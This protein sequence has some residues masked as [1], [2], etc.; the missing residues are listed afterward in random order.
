MAGAGWPPT[1]HG[2]IHPPAVTSA[3]R[4]F[5]SYAR[6]DGT[7]LAATLRRRLRDEHGFSLWQDLADLEGGRDW[8][9]QITGAIDHVEY[10]VLVMTTAALRSAV[11]RQE[12]RYAR[13]QGR[14]VIPVMGAADLDFSALPGWMRRAHCVNPGV[15]EQ[16]TRFVRTLESPCRAT[17]VPLMAE[18]PPPD[19][20]PRRREIDALRSRLL[21]ARQEPVAITAALL[22]AGGY[23]KTTLA[24]AVCH[25]DAVAD[26]FHDGILWVTLG[27]QPGDLAGKVEDLIV[28]L[29]GSPSGLSSLETRTARLR[30]LLADSSVLLVVD[31]LW[32]R[33]HLEPFLAGPRCARLI[34]TR[35]SDTL[36]G[37]AREVRVDAMQS[38]EAVTLLGW[39]LPVGEDVALTRLAGR[40]GEWPLLLTLVNGV[41][42]D[43]IARAGDSLPSALAYADKVLDRRGLTGFD[44]RDA[45]Q[46]HQAVA[47]T[48]GVSLERLRDAE[49]A[50]LRELAVFPEDVEVPIATVELLWGE[51]AALDEFGTEELLHRLAQL[52]LLV[53]FDLATRRV[54]LHDVVRTYLRDEMDA[55]QLAAL[56]AAVVG[57]YRARSPG[58]WANGPDD[59]YFFRHLPGHLAAAG[60]A[61]ELRALLLDFRW[62]T[63]K[64]T[65]A[66]VSALLADYT[67]AADPAVCTLGRALRLS[68]HVLAR[69]PGA[70]ASQLLGRIDTAAEPELGA[71]LA[72]QTEQAG[73]A[74][75]LRPRSASLRPPGGALLQTLVGHTDRVTSVAVTPAGTQLV[76]GSDDHT[77]K[78]WD[79][80][81][82]LELATLAGH[83]DMVLSVA[84]TPDGTRALSASADDTVKIWDLAAAREVATLTG[85]R[86]SVRSVAVS[87]DGRHAVSASD[88]CTAK[89]WDLAS[90]RAVATLT[91]HRRWVLAVVVTP[92]GTRVLSGSG[93]SSL[94]V[95]DL[96]SGRDLATFE[97]H[98]DGVCSL[99]VTPDG[100]R[101]LSG[102]LDK[103]VKVWDL[104]SG[105]ELM[106]LKGHRSR[107]WT[108]AVTPDGTRAVFSSYKAITVC[109]LADG[110]E[111]AS[112]AGHQERV[113]A[114]VVTP[115]GTRAVSGADDRTLMVWDLASQG[116]RAVPSHEGEICT[117]AVTPDGARVVSGSW[118]RTVRVWDVASARPLA[119]LLDSRDVVTSVAVTADGTRAVSGCWDKTLTVW[120]LVGGRHLATLAGHQAEVSSVAVAPDGRR[121]VSGSWDKTV[122]VWDLASGRE[123]AILARHEAE[124]SALAVTPDGTCVVAGCENATLTVTA[125]DGGRALATLSGHAAGIADTV[126]TPDGTRVLSASWD[127]TVKVWDLASGREV[128]T[129]RGHD[130]RVTAIAVTP[131]GTRAISGS[132]DLTL[133]LWDLATGRVLATFYADAAVRAVACAGPHLVVAG[134]ADAVVHFLDLRG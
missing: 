97:G 117:L 111:I 90:G 118:D 130:G 103:T 39:G 6:S 31:D 35:N 67:R 11:V 63:A 131:D 25:D 36:P 125:L 87:R 119:T 85:H 100:T 115:D 81:S 99:A 44:P 22:G 77:V 121:A 23:G 106:A 57:C 49:R 98:D 59:G 84:I 68:A 50:R 107:I 14:C 28:A 18:P 79:L 34:T 108:V 45:E 20:V 60:K 102:S 48:L 26:A 13:Q 47:T 89:V 127:K 2:R 116:R 16:W 51:T 133:R 27:E 19:Y 126:V 7:E 124:V 52:S 71:T 110:R 8:W 122:R 33:A 93:D 21:D 114:A 70:L 88:D 104:A 24:R 17:R 65:H 55:A 74:P 72:A 80:A 29:T 73:A 76:S 101:A 120:D 129:L 134:S 78:L 4:I 38:R 69:D 94:K 15:P 113:R 56:D 92:D 123:L 53:G 62:L 1:P 64:L 40:L 66:G 128:A 46:R 96:A 112:F 42:R 109:D 54:R 132:D 30:E 75:W 61:Q 95:W 91:G 32:S 12:W 105:R 3:P 43:R 5:V 10:V 82:G 9:R 37:D 41:L 58:G 86:A 83:R